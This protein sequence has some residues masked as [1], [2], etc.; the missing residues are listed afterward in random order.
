MDILNELKDDLKHEQ[1]IDVPIEHLDYSYVGKCEDST[2]LKRILAVLKSGKEGKYPALEQTVEEKIISLLPP[3]ERDTWIAMTRDPTYRDRELAR[4][5][6]EDFLQSLGQNTDSSDVIKANSAASGA[7]G[8]GSK[9]NTKIREVPPVRGMPVY[10]GSS[11]GSGIPSSSS[12]ADDTTDTSKTGTA[13]LVEPKAEPIAKQYEKWETMHDFDL[14]E[15]LAAAEKEI[16]ER[17]CTYDANTRANASF[18][19]TTLPFHI[20]FFMI[21][22]QVFLFPS[23]SLSFMIFFRMPSN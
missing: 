10:S 2:E 20:Y 16:A 5:E 13:L 22:P 11:T 9:G 17:V 1:I 12:A 14:D 3:S 4:R 23:I 8:L 6:V 7:S 21:F 19:L 18:F 15:A